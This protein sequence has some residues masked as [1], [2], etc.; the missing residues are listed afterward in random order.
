VT[1]WNIDDADANAVVDQADFP[2]LILVRK[3]CTSAV[4]ACVL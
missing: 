1:N 2:D 3:V 4:H